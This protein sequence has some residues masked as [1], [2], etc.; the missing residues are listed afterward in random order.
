MAEPPPQE[1][2][3]PA[4]ETRQLAEHLFR[5]ESG[6]IVAILTGIF[7]TDRLELAEDVAQEALVRALQS[8]PHFGVP[9]NPS[10]WMTQTAKLLAIDVLRREKSFREKGP[11][12]ADTLER[13]L[14]RSLAGEPQPQFNSEVHD[15]TLRL[16]FVCCHPQL[17][18]QSR[19]M[20]ALKTLCGFG[21]DEIAQAFLST[22]AA[23]AKRLT[24]ARQRIRELGLPFEI[25]AGTEL[26][27]RLDSVLH[28]LYLLFNEGYMASSGEELIREELCAEAIRLAADLARHPIGGKTRTHALLALMLF[29]A[30]R[31]PARK[32]ADGGILRLAEQDRALWDKGMIDAGLRHLA[33]ATQGDAVSEYHLQAA[34]EALHCTA[35][36]DASTDWPAILRRYDLWVR[37]SDSPVVALNRAVALSRVEGPQAALD[38]VRAIPNLEA[39]RS[40]FLLD[41]VLAELEGDLGHHDAAAD[42][43]RRAIGKTNLPAERAFLE[44]EFARY[45]EQ[46]RHNGR[47]PDSA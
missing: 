38:A 1:N 20:L 41:A 35:V 47:S 17:P 29:S 7:G 36:D 31:L 30:S 37:I 26:E 8:W 13:S 42:H 3:P 24:R 12:L 40:Y 10:A 5:H 33:Q 23:V 34:I 16:M 11:A 25:P 18:E 39:L 9:R 15:E 43:C 6:R 2:A 19:I 46:A 28:T 44:R 27:P 14:A 32:D 22:E 4:G 45:Q 21:I